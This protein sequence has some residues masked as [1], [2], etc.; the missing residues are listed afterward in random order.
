L[1]GS[2]ILKNDTCSLKVMSV[3]DTLQPA[4]MNQ[5]LKCVI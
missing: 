3:Q 2:V 4:D 1:S 5:W